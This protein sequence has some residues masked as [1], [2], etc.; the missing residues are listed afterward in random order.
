MAQLDGE[1]QPRFR[2]ADG[3]IDLLQPLAPQLEHWL[4]Q[5][6]HDFV[7]LWQRDHADLDAGFRQAAEQWKAQG[8]GAT[9]PYSAKPKTDR[10]AQINQW[11]DGQT[12]V[13]SLLGD[14]R[15]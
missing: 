11:L 3:A 2:G 1:Q 10:C 4:S 14:C 5:L 8:C 7:P 13:P 15:P 9:S 6:W 12:A